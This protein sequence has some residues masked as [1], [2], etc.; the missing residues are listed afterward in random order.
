MN[1]VLIRSYETCHCPKP[2]TNKLHVNATEHTFCVQFLIHHCTFIQICLSER[3]ERQSL[4]HPYACVPS[5]RERLIATFG[6]GYVEKLR[7]YAGEDYKCC[8]GS[9]HSLSQH[10]TRWR[11]WRQVR[12]VLG[13]VSVS[14]GTS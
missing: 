4:S 7:E 8:P 11:I 9:K 1:A 13:V 3:K 2:K 14:H 6:I 12:P 10:L 5:H